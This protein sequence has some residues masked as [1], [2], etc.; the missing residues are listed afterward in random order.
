MRF[1]ARTGR[2]GPGGSGEVLGLGLENDELLAE[3]S[4][5]RQELGLGAHPIESDAEG[6]GG[7]RQLDPVGEKSKQRGQDHRLPG[8]RR[9]A[10]Q[11]SPGSMTR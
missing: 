7:P 9:I 4:I 10:P 6:N 1:S 11:L 8:S 5:F 3:Q 2:G